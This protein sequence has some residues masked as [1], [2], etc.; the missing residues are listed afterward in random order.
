MA[1][2]PLTITLPP[3]MNP[4][5]YNPTGGIPSQPSSST[6]STATTGLPM[7][8]PL[9]GTTYPH[10]NMLMQNMPRGPTT[11]AFPT[12][13]NPLGVPSTMHTCYGYSNYHHTIGTC[14][15]I[16]WCSYPTKYYFT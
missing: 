12:A 6:L 2:N 4:T 10:P 9:P 3:G 16:D 7:G 1:N 15:T 8:M 14:T 5:F 13:P 11:I